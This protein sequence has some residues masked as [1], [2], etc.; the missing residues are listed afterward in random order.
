MS[1]AYIPT[2]NSIAQQINI[3]IG[4]AI[5]IVGVIGGC[6]N[7]LVFVSLRT[8]R[9]N[10]CAFYLTVMSLFNIG[11]LLTGLLRQILVGGFGIDGTQTSLFYCKWRPFCFQACML[12]SLTNVCFATIDQYWATC[13]RPHWQ[14]WCNIKLAYILSAISIVVW[15]L[16]AVLYLVFMKHTLLPTGVTVCVNTNSI[17]QQY[18]TYVLSPVIG[19]AIPLVITCTFGVLAYNNIRHIAYRTVPLVRR[20]LDKQLTTMVLVQV[21]FAC[22]AIFPAFLINTITSITSL[23]QDPVITAQIQ[24]ISLVTICLYYMYFAVSFDWSGTCG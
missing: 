20:E 3:Y 15:H 23:T 4:S 12:I 16:H 22:F 5:L 6:L 24:L 2:L 19:R 8:F 10:S 21:I 18:V 14:R 17:F 7:L 11:Q 13:C 9:E 1:A